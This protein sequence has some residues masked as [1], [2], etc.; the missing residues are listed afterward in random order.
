MATTMTASSDSRADEEGPLNVVTE[1][2]AEAGRALLDDASSAIRQQVDRQTDR[3]A[4]ALEQL[5]EQFYALADGRPEES[6]PFAGYAIEIAERIV[7][8]AEE[9][10]SESV[11]GALRRV[12]R[13]ARRRPALFV[14][15][16]AALGAGVG[17]MIRSSP[18]EDSEERPELSRVTSASTRGAR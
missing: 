12:E 1:R 6:G 17:R 18:E 7:A 14:L 10:R 16:A 11:G 4:E 8:I 2:A 15:G 5:G 13:A 3:F 9:V